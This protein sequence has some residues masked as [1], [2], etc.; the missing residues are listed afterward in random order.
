MASILMMKLNTIAIHRCQ[1]SYIWRIAYIYNLFQ[2]HKL[3]CRLIFWPYS[4]IMDI[5]V[6]E[7]LMQVKPSKMGT[8]NSTKHVIEKAAS[9]GLWDLLWHLEE[10]MS[11]ENWWNS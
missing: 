3:V 2:T 10:L 1:S 7:H 6:K 9:W 4:I 8:S 11:F 5:K